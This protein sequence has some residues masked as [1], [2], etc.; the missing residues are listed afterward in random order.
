MRRVLLVFIAILALTAG[1]A[2]NGLAIFITDV[3]T[4]DNNIITGQTPGVYHQLTV[5]ENYGETYLIPYPSHDGN[6]IVAA[7]SPHH[8]FDKVVTPDSP[9]NVSLTFV[10]TNTGPY[11]WSDYHFILPSD[12]L[13]DATSDVFANKTITSSYVNFWQPGNV[14]PMGSVSFTLTLTSDASDFDITQVATTTTPLPGAVWLLGGGLAGLLVLR[15]GFRRQ[16]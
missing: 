11:T 6:A 16:S 15:R 5:F 13:I 14:A 9:D 2:Q 4:N 12:N 1:M 7:I 10:V 3:W 8:F